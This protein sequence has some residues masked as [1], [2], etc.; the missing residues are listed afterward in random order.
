V[1]SLKRLLLYATPLFVAFAGLLIVHFWESDFLTPLFTY[2]GQ[3]TSDITTPTTTTE[4]KIGG[5]GEYR[6]VAYFV[7]VR[8]PSYIYLELRRMGGWTCLKQVS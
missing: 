8:I 5:G 3:K 7:N 6:S 2:E 1:A 4:D